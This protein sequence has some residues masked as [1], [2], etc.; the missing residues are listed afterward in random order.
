MSL[1]RIKVTTESEKIVDR[2]NGDIAWV[3][4]DIE[5][6]DVS[7]IDYSDALGFGVFVGTSGN[8]KIKTMG[9]NTVTLPVE[10]G[11]QPIRVVTVFSSGTTAS[12]LKAYI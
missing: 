2:L 7:S 9:G 8:L 4:T 6:I 1:N 3:A 11:F 12:N 10:A 5:D